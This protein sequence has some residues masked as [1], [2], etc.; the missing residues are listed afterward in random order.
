[1]IL[2][3]D[4]DAFYASVEQLDEPRLKGLPVIVG[5]GSARG[6]VCAASYEARR[7]GVRS[8]M[9]GFEAR[10]RCPDGVF[11]RPRMSRYKEVSE[12]VMALLE[13]FSPLVEPVSID[14]AY[15]DASGCDKLH[16]SPVAIG[17]RIKE[18]IFSQLGLTCSVGIAPVKFLAK[19]ASD[20]E[21]PDGLTVIEEAEMTAF[22]EHLPVTRVPGVGKRTFALLEEL[23]V[24]TLGDVKRFPEEILYR[25]LGK[26]GRR[27]MALAHGVDRS[28]VTPVRE[29]KS[30][31][32]ECTLEADTDDTTLLKKLLLA[33]AEEVAAELRKLDVRARTVVLKLKHHDFSQVTR[34]ETLASP[35]RSS[36]VLYREAGR[37]LDRYGPSKKI[38]LVGLGASGFVSTQLPVQQDLFAAAADRGETWEKIDRTL[39]SIKEKYGKDAV[40]RAV[41]RR[42]GDGRSG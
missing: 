34:S 32:S 12:K 4:M 28:K 26:Y 10:R 7:Y 36:S 11:I 19:I 2:H 5:G 41:F 31:S 1:M 9:P 22:L 21:K 3:I 18:E 38:R 13:G 24:S 8:A 6:V 33:Q 15:L 39:E 25:R 30:C 42:G 27:L 40:C 17:R 37:L 16:G 29:H 20:M 35:T 23:G 14:E